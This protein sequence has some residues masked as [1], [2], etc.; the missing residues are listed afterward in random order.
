[1]DL[2]YLLSRHQISLICAEGAAS[3]EAR[4]AHRGFASHY[5]ARI[6]KL[7]QTSGAMFALAKQ[8]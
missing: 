3:E 6:G 8:I 7:Q 4:L 1:M 5:A 2:N